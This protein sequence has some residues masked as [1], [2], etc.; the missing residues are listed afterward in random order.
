MKPINIRIPPPVPLP[1]LRGIRSTHY[2]T[3]RNVKMTREEFAIVTEALRHLGMTFNMFMRVVG[4]Q[5]AQ[6][7]MEQHNGS[8]PAPSD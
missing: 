4:V 7:I 1:Q 6:A 2:G 5:A 8:L 3:I